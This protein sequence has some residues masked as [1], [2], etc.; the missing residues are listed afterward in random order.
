MNSKFLPDIL[1]DAKEDKIM[2]KSDKTG[3]ILAGR[4]KLD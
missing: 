1:S 2:K 3:N 4:G